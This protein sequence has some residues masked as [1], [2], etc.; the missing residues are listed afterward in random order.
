MSTFRNP[1]GPQ[2][3]NVYWRRRLFVG[4]GLLLVVIVILLIVFAPKGGDATKT[5][6]DKTPAA[7]ASSTPPA[8]PDADPT[9]CNPDAISVEAIT[10]AGEYQA[11]VQPL[12]S[13]KITN[14]GTAACSLNAGTDAQVYTI[15]SGPDAIWNSTDCQTA[16]TANPI[17]LEPGE[18][19]AQS[20]TPF[21]WDRTRSSVET[22]DTER[23][24][25]TAGG[26]T[27]KL[28]VS[29]GDIEST[30]DKAFLLY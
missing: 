19:N 8:D 11:G 6:D 21:A 30:E 29:L 16:P 18:D 13:M 14:N 24:A 25:V 23:P 7:P 3:A 20:T 27:Y 12:L 28:S 2:S 10:D 17:V 4:G 22:C 9:A 1:V 15:V 5:A 26:G